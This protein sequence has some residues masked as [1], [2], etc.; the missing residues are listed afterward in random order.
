MKLP[1]FDDCLK[2][3]RIVSFSLAKK[4]VTKELGIAEKDLLTAQKSVKEKDYKWA[5]PGLLRHVSRSQDA[6]I[7]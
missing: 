3:G 7:P 2:R 1:E 5:H 4:L 6:F